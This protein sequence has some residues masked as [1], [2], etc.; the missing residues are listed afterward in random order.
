[1]WSGRERLFQ[2]ETTSRP[3]HMWPDAWTRVG[4]AA[5]RREKQKWAMEKP[6]LEYARNLRRIYSIDPSDEDYKKI[7]LFA[8]RK[9]ETPTA[10]PRK[11]S[12]PK[13][14]FGKPLFRK[15][16]NSRYLEQ[17]QNS[18][19]LLKQMNPQDKELISQGENR[20]LQCITICSP[21]NFHLEKDQT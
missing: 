10:A 18:V 14:A 15:R 8:R 5:Q 17:R 19:V 1:M 4:K 16:E 3:D 21:D 6:K 2:I 13:P 11:E 12:S 7:I 9:L 20:N